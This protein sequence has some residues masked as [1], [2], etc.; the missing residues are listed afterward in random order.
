VLCPTG[1]QRLGSGQTN[2]VDGNSNGDELIFLHTSDGGVHWTSEALPPI[3]GATSYHL[4]LAPGESETMSCPSVTNCTVIGTP[5]NPRQVVALRTSDGG[6][7]WQVNVV[8]GTTGSPRSLSC[9]SDSV[10]WLGPLQT[11]LGGGPI[12]ES[13]DGGLT[14]SPVALPVLPVRSTSTD[15]LSDNVSCASPQ[16]CV[17]SLGDLG[18]AETTDGG[19][20]W[21]QVILP[22]EVGSILQ[23]SCVSSGS[24][25][26]IANPTQGAVPSQ[27]NGG[28]MIVSNGSVSNAA[29]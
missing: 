27:F 14:W 24:C 2:G 23:V 25:V 8:P 19:A 20:T 26:A 12:L 11:E 7:S 10:C 21:Q 18:M 16:S 17:V 1:L 29:S 13:N 28:S 5:P 3:P 22:A 15:G 6:T 4:T 9:P